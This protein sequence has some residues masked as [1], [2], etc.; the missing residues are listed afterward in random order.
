[1]TGQTS[2]LITTIL[3]RVLTVTADLLAFIIGIGLLRLFPEKIGAK[4]AP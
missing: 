4:Q 1:M 2:A 3:F